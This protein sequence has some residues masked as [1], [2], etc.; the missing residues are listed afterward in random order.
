MPGMAA[1]LKALR[2]SL[3][4]RGV[5][6][7]VR[8][9]LAEPFYRYDDWRFDVRFGVQT[10]GVVE[11]G[12][13]DYGEDDR[14]HG[15]N[16]QPVRLGGF[17]E[18]MR[19]LPIRHEEFTFIDFGC[20]KGR[21]LLMASEFP[22]RRIVGVELSPALCRI[23]ARNVQT[24][25]SPSQK[26]TRLE[27]SCENAMAYP[28]PDDPAVLYFF[29]PFDE[30]VMRS[31]LANICF[32]WSAHPRP[33]FVVLYNPVLDPLLEQSDFLRLF[34]RT[35]DSSIYQALTSAAPL[36]SST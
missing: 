24:Y 6:G 29:N 21:A 22:F 8:R 20:G 7:T 26:C 31:V 12:D 33:L 27:I 32:S 35:R 16:Y 15:S 34:R 9:A 17:A 11:A 3:R 10:S 18:F 19:A 28:L 36:P 14:R 2:R 25:S 5:R 30:S 4:D 13:L 1:T 23:A